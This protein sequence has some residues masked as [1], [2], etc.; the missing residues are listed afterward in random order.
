M[1]CLRWPNLQVTDFKLIS[2]GQH[3]VLH[4]VLDERPTQEILAQLL[5]EKEAH[6]VA[7]SPAM[8]RSCSDPGQEKEKAVRA[9][10]DAAR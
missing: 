5:D 9:F 10:K 4:V 7:A 6:Q 8:L 3:P 1:P 2:G